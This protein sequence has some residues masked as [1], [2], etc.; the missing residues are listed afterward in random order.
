MK[1]TLIAFLLSLLPFSATLANINFFELMGCVHSSDASVAPVFDFDVPVNSTVDFALSILARSTN[2][3]SAL[4]NRRILV[5]RV[6][7]TVSIV[8][9]SDVLTPIKDLGAATWTLS[10][11]ITGTHVLINQIGQAGTE[12]D[13][14]T[15]GDIRWRPVAP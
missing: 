4:W 9:F 13:W 3:N 5:K 12:I 7:D 1:R 6:N 2:G 15:Y 11:T 10:G 8:G 14:C